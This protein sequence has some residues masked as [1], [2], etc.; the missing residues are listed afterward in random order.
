VWPDAS[1]ILPLLVELASSAMPAAGVPEL[2]APAGRTDRGCGPGR[3][4]AG[5]EAGGSN[6]VLVG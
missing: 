5:V 6:G 3:F 4:P 1:E 2:P